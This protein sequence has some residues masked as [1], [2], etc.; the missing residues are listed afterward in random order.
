LL[1]KLRFD[2]FRLL[3]L[4]FIIGVVGDEV[5]VEGDKLGVIIIDVSFCAELLTVRQ[6][7]D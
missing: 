2:P 4:D 7:L 1:S 6:K 5:G 3:L